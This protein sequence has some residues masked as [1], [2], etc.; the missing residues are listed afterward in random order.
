MGFMKRA[1]VLAAALALLATGASAKFGI[2]VRGGVGVAYAN[3]VQNFEKLGDVKGTSNVTLAAHAGLAANIGLPA[4]FEVEAGA[5]FA[6]IGSREKTESALGNI[7]WNRSIYTVQVP[8]RLG[9][10]F[11]VSDFL[12]IYAQLGPQFTVAVGGKDTQSTQL[13][14]LKPVETKTAMTFGDVNNR[15]LLDLSIHAGVQLGKGFRVGAYYDL[16]MLNMRKSDVYSYKPS[17][18]GVSLAYFF[19]F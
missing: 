12:G 13:A 16:G 2:G 6:L 14:K 4:G 9:Y 3:Y 1:V 7:S 18:A 15:F 11:S 17:S 8:V 10:C 19:T 5:Q